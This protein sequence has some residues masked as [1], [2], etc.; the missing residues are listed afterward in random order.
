MSLGKR[1]THYFHAD[2]TALGG[3]LEKPFSKNIPTQ[4]PVSLSPAGGE[5]DAHSTDFRFDDILSASAARTRVEGTYLNGLATTRVSAVVENLNVLDTV[6]ADQVSLYISTQH[7]GVQPDIARIDFGKTSI[8]NLRVGDSLLKVYLDL[9]LLS[10][11]KRDE[12]PSR[13]PVFDKGFWKKVGK[14]YDEERDSLQC[15]LVKKIEVARGK[16]PGK[17]V[18]PNILELPEFGR[19]HVAELILSGNSYQVIML[20]FQLGC[21][22]QGDAAVSAGKVNGHGGGG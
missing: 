19:V 10:N 3:H 16:L 13:Q 6:R 21:P 4:A 20:R 2:A 8:T 18:P 1:R 15:T 5:A 12:F 9:E 17:I 11:G 7:P 22:T 14:R